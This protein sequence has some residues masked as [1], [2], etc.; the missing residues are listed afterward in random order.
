MKILISVVSLFLFLLIPSVSHSSSGGSFSNTPR[1][2]EP[3]VFDLVLPLG[4]QKNEY[5]LNAL[6]QHD[7]ANDAVTM[8]PEFEYA[9]ADGYGIEFELPMET[10][11]VA[12]YKMA[13]QGTFDFLNTNQFIHGWQYIGEY[14][15]DA[16]KFENN[17]LYIFG[18]QFNQN[19]SLLNM[20]GSRLSDIRSKGHI[21]GLVNSNLFYSLSKNL[22]MGLETNWE[23]RP[24]RP[25][26]MLV[27]PQLHVQIAQ[28]AKVQF[29]FGVRK[30]SREYFPHVASRVIFGF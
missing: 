12:A 26:M 25:D 1:L 30:A 28:H 27:M 18:Y 10:T 11:G 21:E 3:M 2:P 13:L 20:L 16:K 22:L 24:N 29:G 19:W 14:H 6:F 7:F 17:L 8:N 5:E 4:A 23:F 15:Q 9:Y